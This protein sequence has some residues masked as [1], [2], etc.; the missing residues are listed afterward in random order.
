MHPSPAHIVRGFDDMARLGAQ[1]IFRLGSDPGLPG[2]L[3]RLRD[4]RRVAWVPDLDGLGAAVVGDYLRFGGASL[5]HHGASIVPAICQHSAMKTL[6]LRNVPVDDSSASPN[7]P[8]RRCP[9]LPCVSSPR[10]ADAAW[11]VG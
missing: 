1:T 7:S 9:R 8:R 3:T 6:Y 11:P 5:L 4:G 10:P 2:S